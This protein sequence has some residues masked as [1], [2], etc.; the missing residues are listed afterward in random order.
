MALT[1]YWIRL[2]PS[3]IYI[4]HIRAYRKADTAFVELNQSYYFGK[5]QGPFL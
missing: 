3:H 4:S 5:A 1:Q 2:R